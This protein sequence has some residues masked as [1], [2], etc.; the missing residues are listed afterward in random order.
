MPVFSCQADSG[1]SSQAFFSIVQTANLGMKV[2][3]ISGTMDDFEDCVVKSAADCVRHP[4]H[5]P[6]SHTPGEGTNAMPRLRRCLQDVARRHIAMTKGEW[7][8]TL[9]G[10]HVLLSC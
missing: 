3:W 6:W 5:A 9:A 7:A 10:A 2:K 8:R 4:L 1:I